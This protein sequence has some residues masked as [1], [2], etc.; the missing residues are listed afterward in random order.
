MELTKTIKRLLS[1]V[2]CLVMC[3]S[4][5]HAAAFADVGDESAQTQEDAAAIPGEDGEIV[6]GGEDGDLTDG[7]GDPSG[8]NDLTDGDDLPGDDS[9]TGDDLPGDDSLTD[10]DP[11]GGDGLTGDNGLPEGGDEGGALPEGGDLDD[12]DDALS[13]GESEPDEDEPSETVVLGLGGGTLTGGADGL[14]DSDTLLA[15]Y[16]DSLTHSA[17]GRRKAPGRSFTRR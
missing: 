2:L 14:A 6:V 9:L 12:G 11:T 15:G 7:D 4:L 13:E 10:G 3:F 16:F 5:L 1:V 17:G 8:D